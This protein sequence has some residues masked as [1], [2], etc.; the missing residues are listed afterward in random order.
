MTKCRNRKKSAVLFVGAFAAMFGV[1]N[2]E[3]PAATNFLSD[4]SVVYT[5]T[6]TT[7]TLW[8]APF[9]GSADV[10]LVGGGGGGGVLAGGGGGGGHVVESTFSIVAGQNY[11][12]MVGTGGTGAQT[13]SSV[14]ACVHAANGGTTTAF[15]FTALGGGAGGGSFVV[16]QA[17]TATTIDYAGKDGASGGGA[18]GTNSEFG[19]GMVSLVGDET[20][21]GAGAVN[22]GSNRY[23]GGGGGGAG[24]KGVLAVASPTVA[25]TGGV[26]KLK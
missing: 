1:A 10:L 23:S 13:N 22:L 4:G 7:A 6:N 9:S 2:A 24:G 17:G 16:N 14:E 20:N 5:F 12:I 19:K 11:E 21:D 3:G 18:G 8:T 26:G 25:P 15:G